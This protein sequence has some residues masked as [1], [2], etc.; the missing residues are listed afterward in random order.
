MLLSIYLA[1]CL[2]G[3]LFHRQKVNYR[4]T[5]IFLTPQDLRSYKLTFEYQ[6]LHLDSEQ[7]KLSFLSLRLEQTHASVLNWHTPSWN[8]TAL[9]GLLSL[10]SWQQNNY[11][12]VH[13]EQRRTFIWCRA[14]PL[15]HNTS[16]LLPLCNMMQKWKIG[17]L[18]YATETTTRPTDWILTV[19]PVSSFPV[20]LS[21]FLHSLE[22]ASDVRSEETLKCEPETTWERLLIHVL[23]WRNED[24]LQ[25]ICRS[26]YAKQ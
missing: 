22:F 18:W 8:V 12:L 7:M 21:Q 1:S 4:D 19:C 6:L 14:A 3:I 2:Q 10:L 9:V 25:F 11:H 17:I 13:L 16:L 24:V 15:Q 26:Q 5:L 23:Q 20:L